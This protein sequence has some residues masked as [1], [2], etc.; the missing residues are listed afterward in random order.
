[1]SCE[2]AQHNIYFNVT[3]KI[4]IK[5]YDITTDKQHLYIS[6]NFHVIHSYQSKDMMK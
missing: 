2:Q 4:S 1:L 6:G 5:L 3:I